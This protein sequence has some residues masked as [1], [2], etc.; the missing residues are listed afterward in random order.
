MKKLLLT[1]LIILINLTIS[2]SQDY[3]L[4]FYPVE[5]IN[6]PYDSSIKIYK[7]DN[8][9]AYQTK[10]DLWDGEIDSSICISFVITGEEI[11]LTTID[12][13]RPFFIKRELD[14]LTKLEL[15]PNATYTAQLWFNSA[16]NL[17]LNLDCEDD[18]C[19]GV[20]ITTQYPNEQN[21]GF[22]SKYHIESFVPQD[23][24]AIFD[25]FVTQ[26]MDN[27][28]VS[29]IVLKFSLKDK[30]INDASINLSN[31]EIRSNIWDIDI[32]PPLTEVYGALAQDST[33]DYF[34]EYESKIVQHDLSYPSVNN[35]TYSEFT[36]EMN[37]Q[38]KQTINIHFMEGTFYFQDYTSLR[39]ALVENS[40]TLRHNINLVNYNENL[41]LTSNIVEFGFKGGNKFI[42]KE[43]GGVHIEGDFTCMQFK[44]QSALVISDNVNFHYGDGGI[45]ALNPGS[46][47]EFGNNSVMHLNSK[48][49]LID[50]N[51]GDEEF[52]EIT[53]NPGNT[54][55]FGENA[56]IERYYGHSELKLKVYMNGGVLDDRNLSVESRKHIVKIYP[57]KSE[58]P[59]D[60]SFLYP[61]LTDTYIQWILHSEKPIQV[62]FV[63]FSS[64]GRI[65]EK[66]SLELQVG[67]NITAFDVR[68]YSAGTYYLQYSIEGEKHTNSWIKN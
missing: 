51:S 60:L 49:L 50:S 21:D 28:F 15:S 41:C 66:R 2:I 67:Q 27:Q 64:D 9:L 13:K 45:L 36:S 19:S 35:V 53:L 12:P 17:N 4:D 34:V 57:K 43:S 31:L 47:I 59:K 23:V 44:D 55:I 25:C 65:Y 56:F 16:Q 48:L 32:L 24:C 46:S 20:I 11:D 5:E 6:C 22:E 58:S 26:N 30:N 40:Q 10:N 42:Q 61:T 52:V 54:L 39:G 33:L 18:I 38:I 37:P 29:E 14:P 1:H 8:W 63:L 7:A 62:E 68:Q 3:Y